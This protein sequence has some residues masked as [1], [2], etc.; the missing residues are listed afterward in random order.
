MIS[1]GLPLLYIEQPFGVSI[2]ID[3]VYA[4]Y[5]NQIYFRYEIVLCM[6]Q[7]S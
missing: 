5:Q 3:S 7:V 4:A 2:I 6:L 1:A